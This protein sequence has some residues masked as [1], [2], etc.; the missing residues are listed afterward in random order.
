MVIL[1]NPEEPNQ[2]LFEVKKPWQDL[3]LILHIGDTIE[4]DQEAVERTQRR[5]QKHGILA[6]L[7]QYGSFLVPLSFLEKKE[8]RGS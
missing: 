2:V 1:Q 4:L 8:N 6:N 7:V 3:S 5:M